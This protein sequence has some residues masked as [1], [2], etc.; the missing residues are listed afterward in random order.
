M[1][2]DN[3]DDV[4][5]LEGRTSTELKYLLSPYELVFIDEAQRVK[6]IGLTLKMIGDLKLETQVVVTG[7]S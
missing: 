1:N 5:L 4:L 3:V 7:S 2:C 6:N